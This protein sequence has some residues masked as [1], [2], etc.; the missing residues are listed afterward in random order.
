VA[1]VLAIAGCAEPQR[2]SSPT[3]PPPA[4]R[5]VP[6]ALLDGPVADLPAFDCVRLVHVPEVGAGSTH[7][8]QV[9]SVVAGVADEACA[10]P[11]LVVRAYAIER[12]GTAIPA[13]LVRALD[14]AVARGAEV[15]NISA[16]FRDD[17]PNLRRAIADAV[18]SEAIVV[19]AAGNS[20]GLP[21]AYP[22][23]YPG[24]ISVGSLASSGR[25]SVFS[26]RDGVTVAVQ[27]ED[28]PAL[29]AN[30]GLVE[31]SGTSFAAARVTREAALHLLHG[32]SREQT[33]HFITDRHTYERTH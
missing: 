15:I 29:D 17:A 14:S 20:A 26:A 25:L 6:I 24:V 30:G 22:A 5:S 12:N 33:V 9:A 13:L 19:A 1:I 4:D 31:V 23:A 3:A 18:A 16:A 10:G 21:A 28:V 27:G 7:G 8:T 2:A 11:R 32:A